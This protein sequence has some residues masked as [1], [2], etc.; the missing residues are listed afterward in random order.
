MTME[1]EIRNVLDST[2]RCQRR[3]GECPLEEAAIGNG[4]FLIRTALDDFEHELEHELERKLDKNK[5]KK[6]SEIWEAA[7][8][9]P[10]LRRIQ[11][12]FRLIHRELPKNRGLQRLLDLPSVS[13]M[14]IYLLYSNFAPDST[15]L[16]GPTIIGPSIP[17]KGSS[18]R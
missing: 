9:N 4:I 5:E 10:T 11:G 14:K 16:N 15:A 13:A 7:R 17:V 12:N 8:R 3:L 18:K 6:V 2:A 1:S